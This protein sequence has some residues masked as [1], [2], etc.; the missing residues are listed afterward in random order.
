MWINGVALQK[1]KPPRNA[2]SWVAASCSLR[3]P[4]RGTASRVGHPL[5]LDALL[6]S[7]ISYLELRIT[8]HTITSSTSAP[9]GAR[10]PEHRA[11]SEPAWP[12]GTASAETLRLP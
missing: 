12:A 2:N 7:R 11:L 3:S 5:Q 4:T 6:V 9:A 1:S 10:H 8:N